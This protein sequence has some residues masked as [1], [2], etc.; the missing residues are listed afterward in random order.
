[1][2]VID[3]FTGEEVTVGKV[4]RGPG[5]TWRLDGIVD[6]Y[7]TATAEV[8]LFGAPTVSARQVWRLT[9]RWLHPRHFLKRTAFVET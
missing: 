7:F 2:K 4:M 6:N 9:V 8:T 1:M 3:A 5:F